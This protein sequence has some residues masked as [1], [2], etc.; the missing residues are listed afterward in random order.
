MTAIPI[1]RRLSTRILTLIILVLIVAVAATG[2]L[3]ASYSAGVLRANI[4]QRNLQIARRA[5]SEISLYVRDS[6][7]QL[8]A[9]A[10]ILAPLERQ[11]FLRQAILENLVTNL[12]R[13]RSAVV[14][15][16]DGGV[17]ASTL[18][19]E[20]G[21]PAP[22][23]A[24]FAQVAGGTPYR[25][26]VHLGAN[27]LPYMTVAVGVK[28][29]GI[30]RQVL[31]AELDL[32]DIWKLIDDI[33]VGERGRAFLVSREGELIAH[34]DKSQV[35]RG[36]FGDLVPP[37]PAAIAEAGTVTVQ[38]FPPERGSMLM[39]YV[40]VAGTD[41]VVGLEQP[42]AEAY[43]PLGNVLFRSLVLILGGIALATLASLVMSRR[44]MRPVHELLE[45][46]RIIGD[47]VLEHRI[48][49]R[50]QDEIGRLAASFNDMV[51]HLQARSQQ[52][53]ESEE[54]YRL[55]TENA[56]DLIF[57]LDARGRILFLSS[58]FETLTGYRRLDYLGRDFAE[59]LLPESRPQA[60]ERLAALLAD[61]GRDRGSLEVRVAP[62]DGE[63]IDLEV[64][65]VRV[66]SPKG[67][68]CLYGVGRDVTE[69]K[70]MEAQL[71]QSEKLS[72]LG[73]IVSGVAHEL[74]N[75][76]TSIVGYSQLLMMDG[77]L[78]EGVREDL[79]KLHQEAKRA[80]KIVHNLLGFARQA[81]LERRP[82]RVNAIVQS[83][84]DVRGYE[85]SVSGIRV[86]RSL[87]PDLPV[88][89]ADADQLRQVFLNLANNAIQAL[90]ETER[91][92]VL[93]VA[94][95]LAG[96]SLRVV[97]RDTGPGIPA[98]N[99]ARVFD[100]FFTTKEI[101]KGTGLGLSVSHGI[102]REHGGLIH[103]ASPPGGG[104]VFTVELPLEA[105]P[106]GPAG[107]A[108]GAGE[109]GGLPPLRVLVVDD[110]P[111]LLRFVAQALAGSGCRVE[112]VD[113]GDRALEL[114]AGQEY[115]QIVA[116]VRMPGVDGWQLL[117]W[118]EHHRPALLGRLLFISGDTVNPRVMEL[119]KSSGCPLLAKPFGVDQLVLAVRRCQA[120]ASEGPPG[121][122]SG[123]P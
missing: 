107:E 21:P 1:R 115:D 119:L 99:L 59:L 80:G 77:S 35:L 60:E 112:A 16:R 111:L 20:D 122:G 83:V 55:L 106:H 19:G 114:L 73:E 53:Q 86:E 81:P 36:G 37:L 109:P 90:Q 23:E 54:N 84:L 51:E 40:P 56:S 113:R 74:N 104:A 101:G 121:G 94:T 14:Y 92:R 95:S 30:V 89:Q 22:P 62:S 91:E 48:P 82:C 69:R 33:T 79:D 58:R 8:D 61:P 13:Y 57:S 100:P 32:R 5:G 71:V 31:V 2:L 11:P 4:S 96:E 102:V 108:A 45:G 10:E 123:A 76:L 24:A 26:S 39:V 75:P 25:S 72:S 105:P 116:D 118:L 93:S 120:A 103:A 65:L 44:L 41:W 68:N 49:V 64:T 6:L 17:A 28:L 63:P 85:M 3:I 7:D 43:L 78:S 97:F 27:R 34:R 47:G 18:L 46:T 67:T 117:R 70:K 50:D 88:I 38:D 29:L 66:P 87:E 12:Q 15:G 42:V 98:E 9:V 52:L 110:E